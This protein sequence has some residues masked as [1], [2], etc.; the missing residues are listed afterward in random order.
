MSSPG[1][2]VDTG[3]AACIAG[4]DVGKMDRLPDTTGM[5]TKSWYSADTGTS[6]TMPSGP[7]V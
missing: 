4:L 2:R 7:P 3:V 6:M 5:K 1:L